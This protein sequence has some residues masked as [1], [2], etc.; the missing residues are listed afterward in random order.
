MLTSFE[1]Q[2]RCD[3]VLLEIISNKGSLDHKLNGR[4]MYN[5]RK[6]LYEQIVLDI[7]RRFLMSTLRYAN[8]RENLGINSFS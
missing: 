2:V 4:E 6:K 1:G 7:E 3:D 5:K 8:V